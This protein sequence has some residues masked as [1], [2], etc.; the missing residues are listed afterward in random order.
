[1]STS[2]TA[3][4]FRARTWLKRSVI[5]LLAVVNLAVF[6]VYWQLRTIDEVVAETAQT[7]PDLVLEL[8]PTLPDSTDPITFL[9]VGS[10]SRANLD[11]LEGF[12]AAGGE[13]SDVIM[14][15]KIFPDE[16]SAK[17]LSLPR[18]LWVE[19]PGNGESKINAAYSL[20]GASLVIQTVKSVTGIEINHYVEVDFVGFQSIVDELGG[21]EMT[22]EYPAR[23]TKSGLDVTAGT[24]LL[25]GEEAL[26]FA[27]SRSYQELEGGRWV[28]VDADDFGRAGRQQQLILA[29]LDQ[30]RRPST[31]TEAG[32][33]VE[34]FASY[35]SM[36]EALADSSMIEL[37]FRMRS[38]RPANIET[39]TL[40]GYSS[41]I[42]SQSVVLPDEPAASQMLAAF[43]QG[44]SMVRG[45]IDATPLS[46]VVLNGNGVPDSASR[47]SEL[48]VSLGFVVER[49]ADNGSSDVSETVVTVRSGAESRAESIVEAL[50]FGRI[51]EGAVPE[52]A[53]VVVL[54]GADA[55]TAG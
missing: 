37:A 38:L 13:R 31:L 40:P 46:V 55:E 33:I 8:A 22:F 30:M 10:D 9:L 53:D 11:D 2:T 34:S 49:V 21:I 48:L 15:I 6:Y 5:A 42:G 39:A 27:R 51:E 1:M 47:W 7:V 36:D 41:T 3:P 25:D 19:I 50:G 26:A 4:S 45:E 16:G 17:I 35:V 52:G 24:H 43:R 23:D 29:I 32:D 20:G 28:S 14:L 44:A 12:G 18:D 54:L